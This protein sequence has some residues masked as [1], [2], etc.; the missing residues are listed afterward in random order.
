MKKWEKFEDEVATYIKEKLYSYDVSVKQ[1]GK[2]NSTVPDILITI[3][4]NNK[5]F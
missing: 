2:E 1:Y 5:K 4:K 3:N